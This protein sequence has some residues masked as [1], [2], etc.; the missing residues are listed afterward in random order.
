LSLN[1]PN[2]HLRKCGEQRN[3]LKHFSKKF[4]DTV[5]TTKTIFLDAPNVAKFFMEKIEGLLKF[6]KELNDTKLIENLNQLKE[7]LNGEPF[8]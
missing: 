5:K 4:L 8:V 2:R 3:K 1:P 6:A 7:L